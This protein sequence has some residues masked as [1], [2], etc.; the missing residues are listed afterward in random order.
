MIYCPN[1]NAFS[2]KLRRGAITVLMALLLP[3]LVIVSAFVINISFLQLSKTEL[4]VAT[5]AAARAGGRAISNYQDIDDA[6]QAAQITA[7]LN[8]VNGIP[9]QLNADETA[10]DIEFGD[11]EPGENT[12]RFQFAE[13]TRAQIYDGEEKAAAI[14]VHG[15]MNQSSLSGPIEAFFPT[16]GMK[17]EFDLHQTAVAMQVDRDIALILDR[18]SSM[19]WHP[20]WDWPSGY[21][22]WDWDSLVAGYYAGILGYD[23]YYGYFYYNSG[24]NSNSYQTWLWEEHF[25]LGSAPKTP[26]EELVE[27]VGVFLDVLDET[28]QDEQVSI[29]SYASTASL[30]ITLQKNYDLIKTELDSLY[31]YG[32]TAIGEGM[33][34]GIP[35]LLDSYSRVYAAKTL[36]VMTDGV[37]NTGTAPATVATNIVANYDVTIH[38]ITFGEGADQIAMENVA[39]IGGGEHYHADNGAELQAIFEEIANNLPTIVTQ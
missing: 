34:T 25:E 36:L 9:L 28:D 16:F 2:H 5:D 4:M 39:T 13:V 1:Q 37:H 14:R 38:T 8:S 11:A 21:D 7:M 23:F 29:A 19:D 3:V 12:E 35:T 22:P 27:A 6:I 26:W 32:N 33:S 17:D 30:D 10:G 15:R 20:G 24:Q 31:P 18:S